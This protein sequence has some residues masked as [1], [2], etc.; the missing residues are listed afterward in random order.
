MNLFEALQERRVRVL[1][2]CF[3]NSC[4]S[5]MA[6]AFARAYGSDVLEASSAGI[7]PA[8]RLSRRTRAVIEETGIPLTEYQAPKHIR[9]FDLREFDLIVNLS[10]YGVPKTPTPVLRIPIRDP[11][12]RETD[13]HRE[14]RDQ[15]EAFVRFLVEQFRNAR[16]AV[17]C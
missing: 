7:S 10:E 5:Q 15:V 12:G 8:L 13:T 1:F 2:V 16:Q 9:S 17:A 14:V 3:G 6:E 11:M 4:R